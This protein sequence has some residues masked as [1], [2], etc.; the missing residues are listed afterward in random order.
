MA[1]RV[2]PS[3]RISITKLL[4]G[5]IIALSL[6]SFTPNASANSRATERPR[7]EQLISNSTNKAYSFYQTSVVFTHVAIEIIFQ[8][9]LTSFNATVSDQLLKNR[10]M[11][12]T[13]DQRKT[14]LHLTL[15]LFSTEEHSNKE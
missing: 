8:H 2:P 10:M 4:A 13:F 7:T 3:F 1:D 6:F 14:I 5:V 15:H 11:F 12:N 9:T